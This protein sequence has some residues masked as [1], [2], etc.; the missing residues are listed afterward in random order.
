VTVTNW[1]Y[2]AGDGPPFAQTGVEPPAARHGARQRA[3]DEDDFAA[4]Q[5]L[6]IPDAAAA[7]AVREEGR[8]VI[9]QRP[10]PTGWG[11]WRPPR[12]W[13]PLKLPD[14]WDAV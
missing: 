7:T 5:R 4:A 8:R 9:A 13:A 3:Q 6:G 10:W 2:W 14:G 12:E 11:G 1:G